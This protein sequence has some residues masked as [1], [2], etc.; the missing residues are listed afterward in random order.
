MG[1]G[2]TQAFLSELW[3]YKV[4]RGGHYDPPPGE[5]RVNM[6]NTDIEEGSEM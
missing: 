4:D 6:A 1:I 2:P 3:G 5:G